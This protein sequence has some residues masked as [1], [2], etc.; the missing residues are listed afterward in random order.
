[1][2]FFRKNIVDLQINKTSIQWTQDVKFIS[3]STQKLLVKNDFWTTKSKKIYRKNGKNKIWEK[4]F[5]RISFWVKKKSKIFQVQVTIHPVQI[6]RRSNYCITL[7][8]LSL[9]GKTKKV[10][11]NNEVSKRGSGHYCKAQT[12]FF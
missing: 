6:S 5:W 3:A 7:F 11:K 10:K 1:M 4:F 12:R 2:K 9:C 8:T